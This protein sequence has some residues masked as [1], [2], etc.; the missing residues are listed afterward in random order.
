MIRGKVIPTWRLLL[1]ALIAAQWV[2]PA[3]SP[4]QSPGIVMGTIRD[5]AGA[6]IAG[7]EVRSQSGESVRS[8]DLGQYRISLAHLPATLSVRRL[9]FTSSSFPAGAAQPGTPIV[10]DHVLR[11]LPNVLAPV[12]VRSDRVKYTG[13]LAGY[14]E[15]LARRAG[16]AFLSREQ[17]DQENA[18][19]LSQLLTHVPGINAVRMRGGGGGVRFRSRTCWPLVWLDGMPMGAGEV[20]LDAFPP[21]TLHGIEIYLGSTTAPLRYTAPRNMSSCGTILLW[22][23]GPDTDPPSRSAVP[24]RDLERLISSFAVYTAD[25]VDRPA[26][27]DT[28]RAVDVAYPAALL[29]AG[30]GGSVVAEFVVDSKG[31]VEAGTVGI[32][33]STDPELSDAVRDAVA[34]AN[35]RPALVGGKP[36]R[37]IVQQPFT[38]PPRPP[39]ERRG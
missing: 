18:R 7:A 38:F 10:A 39:R 23:R 29:A 14:Y 11:S 33:S 30:R 3:V 32:V 2:V 17:I 35:F 27:L 25:Q 19:S 15:R 6:A 36:V 26:T 21:Q 12:V 34:Q 24:P 16:G 9:G 37:Q 8:D 22:S 20:D 1:A 31:D 28:R 5:S 4:G 13:R